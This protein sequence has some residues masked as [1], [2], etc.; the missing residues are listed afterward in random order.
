MVH[1]IHF[2]HGN[3]SSSD[4]FTHRS[5]GKRSC[6]SLVRTIFP[7]VCHSRCSGEFLFHIST[8]PSRQ[9]HIEIDVEEEETKLLQKGKRNDTQT[10]LLIASRPPLSLSLSLSLSLYSRSHKTA[11][12]AHSPY[13]SVRCR[14]SLIGYR[15]M[16]PQAPNGISNKISD[17]TTNPHMP[18]RLPF[19]SSKQSIVTIQSN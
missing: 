8:L 3:E 15:T 19:S 6:K 14:L 13:G 10:L 18:R 16:T 17:H 12:H 7:D 4:S 11:F 1:S 9:T 2:S 5:H